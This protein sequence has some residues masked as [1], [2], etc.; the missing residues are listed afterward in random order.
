MGMLAGID[1]AGYG[2]HLGPLVVAAAAFE[3]DAAP[4]PDP[5][6]WQALAPHITKQPSRRAGAVVICDSKVAYSSGGRLATLE[7]TVLG[8]LAAA[9][10]R[11][12][13]FAELLGAVA[14]RRD[15]NDHPAAQ[16]PWET[17]ETIALPVDASAGEVDAAAEHLARG[18]AAIGG[19]PAGLW[20]NAASASRLNGLMDGR[21]NKAG[22]LF[23]LAA[24]LLGEVLRW[25]AGGPVHCANLDG[26][27]G[28]AGLPSRGEMTARLPTAGQASRATPLEP[29]PYGP[30]HVAMDRHGGRRYYADLLSGA[31]PM[32]TV[33]AVEE[34]PTLS[35][36][37]L[38]HGGLAT[39]DAQPAA[40]AVTLTVR[41]RCEE[42]STATA[43]A[44]MAAKYVRELAMRQ[45][46]AY[47]QS[48]VPG[49]KATAGYGLDAWRFLDD[50]ATARAAIGVPD[51][52]ILRSR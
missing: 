40:G 41:E 35:R 11:P 15:A 31:F 46:N 32:T 22:A 43:L 48:R 45:L 19:R 10:R 12:H 52:A 16:A 4:L 25:G 42:W 18:L 26:E 24:D 30:I 20:V 33:E 8:F 47:F 14:V 27:G 6:L 28:T 23:T 21:R 13:T 7:R 3:F 49:L 5:D 38:L 39:G 34:S 29:T 1:E 9:G 51:A 17:P 44:S 2:P 36:Y 37:R 50:T